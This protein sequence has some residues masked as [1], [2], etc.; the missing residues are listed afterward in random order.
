M[1]NLPEQKI[2]EPGGFTDEFYQWFKEELM[3][4][5]SKLFQKLRRMEHFQS[6]FVRLALPWYWS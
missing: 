4:I 5:L 1:K 3:P 6:R 2:P